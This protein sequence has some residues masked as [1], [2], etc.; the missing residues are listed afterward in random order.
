M[1][2]NLLSNLLN[3]KSIQLLFKVFD[4]DSNNISL[5]GG[6]VRDMLLGKISNDIDMAANI[7]P[8]EVLKI[9]IKNDLKY[10]DYAYKYGSITT[11]IEDQKFHITTLREDVNQIGRHSNIIF[12]SD[13]KKDAARRDFT[14]NSMY[15]LQNGKLKDFF[16]GKKDLKNNTLR[17]IGNIEDSIQE[18]FLRIFRYYRFLGIF[19][20][21]K[22]IEGYD[23]IL[24]KYLE[25][26]FDYISDD[27]IRQEILKMFNTSFPINCFFNKDSMKKK[28]WINLVT[29]KFIKSS[30]Y[31]GL[32]KCLNKIDLLVNEKIKK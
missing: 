19:K 13:W 3:K 21:P 11:F 7:T 1:K 15:L 20:N 31:I 28:Y 23:N 8:N 16:N 24:S 18:D 22:I 4:D 25:K 10:E 27:L 2:E 5:V 17:F 26:A 9:L 6:C 32:N 29:K 30:Y 12:T 14:I